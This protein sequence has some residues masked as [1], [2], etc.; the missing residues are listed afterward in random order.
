MPRKRKSQ[1]E[2]REEAVMSEYDDELRR[3]LEDIAYNGGMIKSLAASM[4]KRMKEF[5]C[6]IPKSEQRCMMCGTNGIG[7][8]YNEV[9]AAAEHA[10]SYLNSLDKIIIFKEKA[11]APPKAQPKEP[12]KK[13]RAS[14]I[15]VVPAALEPEKKKRN[16]KPKFEVVDVPLSQAPTQEPKKAR[17]SPKAEA[18]KVKNQKPQ[19]KK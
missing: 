5:D 3:Q 9:K 4:L 2:E 12:E 18:A 19:S 14:K 7:R 10:E 15:K 16:K 8:I 6:T 17:W 1:E 13:T 11:D